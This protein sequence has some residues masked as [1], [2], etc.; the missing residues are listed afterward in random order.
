M[1]ISQTQLDYLCQLAKAA[2]H[3]IMEVYQGQINSWQK[4]DKSPLT[5][6]DLRADKVIRAGLESHFPNVFIL[7]EESRSTEQDATPETF[8]LVDPLDGTKEFLKRN[9]EFTVNIALVHRGKVIAGVVFAPAL[10]ELFYAAIGLGCWKED[11][12]VKRQVTIAPR[13]ETQPLRIIGSRSHGTDKL[14]DWL[15]TLN[16]PYT[17]ITAGSSLKFCRVA[18]G[19]ADIYPRFTPTY[20]WDTAAGQCILEQS[21]GSVVS[22][23][24]TLITYNFSKQSLNPLFI[25]K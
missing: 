2:G 13:D 15:T 23:C 12:T 21:G 22:F 8:F 24:G 4:D 5:E 14:N 7:S 25:A 17:L 6:A 19:K 20:Y 9:D 10:N 18:E 16:Q 1:N 3:E 11:G